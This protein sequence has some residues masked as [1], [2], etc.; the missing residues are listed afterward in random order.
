MQAI[1]TL[2]TVATAGDHDR[3]RIRRLQESL[4]LCMPQLLTRAVSLQWL[5][6]ARAWH[7]HRL[8][9]EHPRRNSNAREAQAQCVCEHTSSAQRQVHHSVEVR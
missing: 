7:P 1:A 3:T 8:I 9:G 2:Q 6:K 5:S 4:I